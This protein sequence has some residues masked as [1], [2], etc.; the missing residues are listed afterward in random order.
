MLFGRYGG[1][2]GGP[3]GWWLIIEPDIRL[4][5]NDIVAPD[6][7]G[8]RRERM[9]EFPET[10][11]IDVVPDWICE[12]VSPKDRGRDRVRKAGLYLRAAMPHYW[13]LDPGQRT[14]EAFTIRG[15]LGLG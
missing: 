7:V 9:P 15:N 14:L 2:E 12:V 10:R 13:I 5:P 6:L 11:P 4:A 3:G 8:W 1:G